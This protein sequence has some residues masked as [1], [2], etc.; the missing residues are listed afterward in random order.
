MGHSAEWVKVVLDK[1]MTN[2]PGEVFQHHG[3]SDRLEGSPRVNVIKGTWQ[4]ENA[5]LIE[6]LGLGVGE[7]PERW[8]LTFFGG[9]VYLQAK[10]PENDEIYIEGQAG[11]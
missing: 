4:G 2:A 1:R 10:F 5:F 8:T 11:R 3:F 9:K 6:R 7:P